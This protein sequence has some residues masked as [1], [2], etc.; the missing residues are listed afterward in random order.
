MTG[1]WD[2][3]RNSSSWPHIFC[4]IGNVSGF[5]SAGL[6]F[7]VLFPQIVKNFRLR[8]VVGLSFLWAAA[9]FTASLVNAFFVFSRELPLYTN[10]Q[11]VYQPC[12]ELTILFQFLIFSVTSVHRRLLALLI[13]LLLWSVIIMV[14]LTVDDA[15]TYVYWLAVFLWSVET[16]PQVILN[17][18]RRSTSGQSTVSVGIALVGKVYM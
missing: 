1:I 2:N 13:C 3:C 4:A 6:W 10:I 12:L 5:F 8:S 15:S 16:F 17:M 11:S 7:L 14:E 9:N 18:N